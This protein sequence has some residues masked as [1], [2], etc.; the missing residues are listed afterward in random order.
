MQ[1]LFTIM[2]YIYNIFK[3]YPLKLN[4]YRNYNQNK[5]NNLYIRK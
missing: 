3:I 5:G 1:K 2:K 4:F